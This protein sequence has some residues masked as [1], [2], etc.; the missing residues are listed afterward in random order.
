LRHVL[1]NIAA[2]PVIRVDEFLPWHCAGL[3][4]AA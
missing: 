4:A 1:A 3:L 2:H